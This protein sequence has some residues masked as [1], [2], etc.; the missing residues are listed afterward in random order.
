MGPPPFHGLS[1]FNL[2]IPAAQGQ[3]EETGRCEPARGAR[4]AGTAELRGL[5]TAS[6]LTVRAEG[7]SVILMGF[8]RDFDSHSLSGIRA[9]L[10]FTRSRPDCDSAAG[11]CCWYRA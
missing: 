5:F 4:D 7:C 1:N 10:A 11:F 9:L 2:K 8:C 6:G 3:L